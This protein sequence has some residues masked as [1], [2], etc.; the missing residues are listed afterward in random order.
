MGTPM[1]F[2]LHMS[3]VLFAKFHVLVTT[4]S[5]PSLITPPLKCFLK[6]YLTSRKPI[7]FENKDVKYDTEKKFYTG[8]SLLS[9]LLHVIVNIN[10]TANLT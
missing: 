8:M 6:L 2:T 3:M 7:S 4:W 1:D 10:I 5:I 9:L